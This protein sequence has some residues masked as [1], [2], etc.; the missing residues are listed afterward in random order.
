MSSLS[1]FSLSDHHHTPALLPFHRCFHQNSCTI[2][3]FSLFFTTSEGSVV[4]VAV[5][6]FFFLNPKHGLFPLSRV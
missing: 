1:Y 3:N 4:V 2:V 5:V 6:V